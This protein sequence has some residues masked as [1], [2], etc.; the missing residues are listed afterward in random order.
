MVGDLLKRFIVKFRYSHVKIIYLRYGQNSNKF[1]LAN[2]YC[3]A[4]KKM[5]AINHYLTISSSENLETQS[6]FKD[7]LRMYFK[8]RAT[9]FIIIQIRNKFE[10]DK[11]F[12]RNTDNIV[13]SHKTRSYQKRIVA[14]QGNLCCTRVKQEF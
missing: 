12:R 13:E 5:A 10:A 3:R 6:R 2:T 9:R 8:H 1:V 14:V 11:L 7:C 4:K